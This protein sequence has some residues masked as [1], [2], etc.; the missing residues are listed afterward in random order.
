[1][2]PE[3]ETA[4]IAHALSNAYLITDWFPRML[5]G[6]KLDKVK[7]GSRE[8]FYL[9]ATYVFVLAIKMEYLCKVT[10]EFSSTADPA[11]AK[12]VKHDIDAINGQRT[13]KLSAQTAETI[14]LRLFDE[15]GRTHLQ[16]LERL[17]ERASKT[18]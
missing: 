14:M 6:R 9:I 8:E 12:A 15:V 4:R 1:M 3:Q 11:L 13:W 5:T 10:A 17:A 7:P 16:V 2:P 18:Q